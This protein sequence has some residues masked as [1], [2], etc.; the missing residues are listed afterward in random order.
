M[1]RQV[2][3]ALAMAAVL[4]LNESRARR[5]SAPP[6]G[7]ENTEA[8]EKALFRIDMELY[9]R[10]LRDIRDWLDARIAEYGELGLYAFGQGLSFK[11]GEV[12]VCMNRGG[13]ADSAAQFFR[14]YE[15]LGEPRYLEAGLK[16]CDFFLRIQQPQGH[17]PYR[18]VIHQPDGRITVGY[19]NRGSKQV[20]LQDGVQYRPFALLLYAHRLTGERRYMLAAQRIAD[21]VLAIQDPQFGYC[22]DQYDPEHTDRTQVLKAGSPG[23]IAVGGSYNDYATTDA[24]RMA[25]MMYHATGDRKYLERSARIGRWI[26]ATQIGEDPVHGWCQQY[27]PNNEPTRARHHELEVIQPY[28]FNRFVGPM[29]AWFYGM[30]GRQ[31]Y[32]AMF[33]ETYQWMR[34][35]EKDGGWASHYLPD[36]TPVFC[37][38]WEIHRYDEPEKWKEKYPWGGSYS[39]R[40][41]QLRDASRLLEQM[42]SGGQEGVRKWFH[43]PTEFSP[44]QYLERQIAAARRC[45]DEDLLVPLADCGEG[46]QRVDGWLPVGNDLERVRQRWAGVEAPGLAQRIHGRSGIDRQTWEP[47]HMM[48]HFRPPVGWAQWQY[49]W[50]VRLALGDIDAETAASGGRGLE[51]HHVWE[52]WDVMGDWTTRALKVERWLDVALTESATRSRDKFR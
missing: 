25:V 49:V 37:R 48:P 4:F 22:P 45:A 30:T 31:A 43:G 12:H 3:L 47:P 24:M 51:V 38:D 16:T 28:V 23:G 14:A 40:F 13:F 15:M 52:P 11:E 50:D 33:K 2:T 35:V 9:E 27:G 21:R 32:R 41:V 36:G 34:S 8:L 29:L 39:R 42:H 20:R 10:S 44:G 26:L 46:L 17:I 5:T 18:A 6:E 1:V 7:V 19:R